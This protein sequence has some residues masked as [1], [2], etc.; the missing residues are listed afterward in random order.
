MWIIERMDHRPSELAHT[1]AGAAKLLSVS[2]SHFYEHILPN[3]RTVKVGR[4][5][6][7]P[8]AELVAWLERMANL[9]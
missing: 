6:L 8:H 5:T 7:V 2:R 1:P 3:L 4:K 9:G